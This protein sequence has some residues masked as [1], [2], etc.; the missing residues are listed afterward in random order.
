VTGLYFYDERAPEFAAQLK[1]SPRG[2]LEI[3]DLN[4]IYLELGELQVARLGRGFAWLD[5]GTP[6]ALI[7]A[8]E[9]VRAIEQRQGQRVACLEEIAFR[10]G[11]I[12]TAQARAASSKLSKSGYGQY[13]SQ[14]LA[15]MER[16]VSPVA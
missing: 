8:S 13:I 4:R 3:T 2:E 11:W 16:E 6:E 15:E 7:E 9:Y 1:P 5:T 10:A 14:V 12:D